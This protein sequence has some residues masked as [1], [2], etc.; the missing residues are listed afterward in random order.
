MIILFDGFFLKSLD[1]VEFQFSCQSK[2]Q[3]TTHKQVLLRVSTPPTGQNK[4]KHAS[5]VQAPSQKANTFVCKEMLLSIQDWQKA[6]QLVQ[7]KDMIAWTR[8]C[9]KYV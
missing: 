1:Y 2:V 3:G 8:S 9:G 5:K 4:L 7:A 6:F